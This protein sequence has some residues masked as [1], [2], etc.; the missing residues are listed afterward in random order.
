MLYFIPSIGRYVTKEILQYVKNHP[1][2]VKIAVA[3]IIV[4]LRGKYVSTENSSPSPKGLASV[5]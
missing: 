2:G 1:S 3:D 5:M 4:I